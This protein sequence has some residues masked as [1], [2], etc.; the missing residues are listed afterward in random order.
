MSTKKASPIRA[1][2]GFHS[3]TDAN[4]LVLANTVLKGMTGNAAYTNPPVTMATFG[5]DLAAYSAAV[6]AAADGGKNAKAAR[7]KERKAVIKDLRE[8]AMYVESNCNEDMTIFTSSGF[9]AKT[10]P[11]PA[12]TVAVPG[13]KKIDYGNVT[14]QI[15]VTIQSAAG[16]KAYNLRYAVVTNGTPGAWTVILIA[17]IRKAITIP[18][19]TPGTTYAFQV[20]ALGSNNTLSDWSDSTNLM[21]T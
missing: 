1:V 13:F 5:T 10:K 3:L 16:A 21:S 12:A 17:N 18:N 19:L 15:L 4:L 14:G 9:V 8:L 6:S 11:S 20:Q 2:V 7:D